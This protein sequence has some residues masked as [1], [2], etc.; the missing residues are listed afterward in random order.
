MLRLGR[1]V[2]A[3]LAQRLQAFGLTPA[4]FEVLQVL[5]AEGAISQREIGDRMCCAN[6]N[7]TGLLDRM[8]RDGLVRRRR[9]KA[10]R[11]VIQVRLTPAGAR[12]LRAFC[13]PATC[14]A[15]LEKALTGAQRRDLTRL[16]ERLL[17][18]IETRCTQEEE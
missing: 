17:A 13:D 12:K 1:S 5:D 7:V 15:D 8:E 9:S 16:M 14:C 11:R 3:W 6:S 10:D 2:N 4:Q 18:A